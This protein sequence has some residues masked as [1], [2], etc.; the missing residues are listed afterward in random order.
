MLQFDQT[1]A[2][3][4]FLPTLL[5]NMLSFGKDKFSHSVALLNGEDTKRKSS[6][7]SLKSIN[8]KS[9]LK[10]TTSFLFGDGNSSKVAAKVS[11]LST[12][13]IS[14]HVNDIEKNGALF[15]S[16]ESMGGICASQHYGREQVASLAHINES[17]VD[18]P[19]L[20]GNSYF[21]KS[22]EAL[23][24]LHYDYYAK[25]HLKTLE[26]AEDVSALLEHETT[27]DSELVADPFT[28]IEKYATTTPPAELVDQ[29]WNLL[30]VCLSFV[31]NRNRGFLPPLPQQLFRMK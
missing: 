28:A 8:L 20:G 3:Y 13:T 19:R 5:F 18:F 22:Q 30:M 21:I 17:S 27:D 4:V 9:L 31:I 10:G 15:A 6:S 1:V 11:N 14:G 26:D 7:T 2:G 12:M 29:Y 23:S 25:Y 16:E 24:S